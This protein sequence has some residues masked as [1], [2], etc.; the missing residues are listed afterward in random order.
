MKEKIIF[1]IWAYTFDF[2]ALCILF[3]N[4][5]KL[6]ITEYI[7]LFGMLLLHPL[8]YFSIVYD[9]N[10]LLNIFHFCI[11]ILLAF[12]FVT[13]NIYV[14]LFILAFNLALNIQ[15]IL[16]D[17]RC[18][19]N[20]FHENDKSG[21]SSILSSNFIELYTLFYICYLCIKIGYLYK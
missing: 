9:K 13:N 10:K 8:L 18:I 16:L 2:F 6:K 1:N 11:G 20:F 15:W 3:F 14:L 7:F 5:G 4:L 12:G 21:W 19:I 17:G